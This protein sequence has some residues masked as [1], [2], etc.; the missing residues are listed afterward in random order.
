MIATISGTVQEVNPDSVVVKWAGSVCLFRACLRGDLR[1]G[2]RS[3]SYLYGMR[4]DFLGLYGFETKGPGIT[5]DAARV[6][7]VGPPGALRTLHA[8]AR[9]DPALF[10][11]TTGVLTVCPVW[12]RRRRRKSVSPARPHPY[13]GRVEQC[14]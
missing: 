13:G 9:R 2:D 12:E 11:R 6:D 4:Q 7:G 3:F 5:F 8:I 1:A 14:R 10:S